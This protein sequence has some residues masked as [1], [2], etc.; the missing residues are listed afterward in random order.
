MLSNQRRW[1]Y[2][3]LAIAAVICSGFSFFALLALGAPSWTASLNILSIVL[4]LLAARTRSRS[5]SAN[6]G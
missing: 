6:D 4:V 2:Y 3:G 1:L 5:R